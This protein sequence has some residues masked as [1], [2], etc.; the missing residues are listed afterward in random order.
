[1]SDT[2]EVFGQEYTGVEGFKATDSNGD[3]QRYVNSNQFLPLTGGTVTG[4][5]ILSNTTDADVSTETDCALKIGDVTGAHM[6]FDGNEIIAK[7]SETTAASLYI[8]GSGGGDVYL[9]ESK[10]YVKSSGGCEVRG[11]RIVLDN[12]RAFAAKDTNGTECALL[13]MNTA[14]NV[15]LNAGGAGKTYLGGS[16]IHFNSPL[17][18]SPILPIST[19]LKGQ[20]T[21]GDAKSLIY[22]AA[23][24]NVRINADSSGVTQIVS[25]TEVTGTIKATGTINS[26]GGALIA[27]NCT[28][29][30]S[31]TEG[32]YISAT[33]RCALV[34]ATSTGYPNIM[35]VV[36]KSTS[37]YTQIRSTNAS[38]TYT[39]TLPAASG[40]IATT[41]SDIRLKENI[42]DV[43]VSGLEL[44]NKIK[45]HQFDWKE[46]G[47][48]GA[49]HWKVGVI[50]DELQELDPN[51]ASGGGYEE[52]GSMNVKSV[53]IS[54]MMG[55]LI[56]AVQEL[57]EEI[58]GFKGVK[59]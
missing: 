10:L 38:G 24:N 46:E 27:N 4:T 29:Y 32:G 51:L 23:N 9:A 18:N 37:T 3:T 36:N 16:A 58:K 2:L 25:N 39:L 56:K 8:N 42:K 20:D 21:N 43:E 33:G 55:Y 19:P 48:G 15:L 30:N 6:V 22:I 44:I 50:A 1:M 14:N 45:L 26:S 5:L 59:I 54:Y 12:N 28:A 13:Y 47:H 17:D 53:E 49:P 31:G 52:D 35:F 34:S 40:T 41:S 11:G 7:A 57:S